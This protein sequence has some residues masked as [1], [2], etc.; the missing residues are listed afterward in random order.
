MMSN[1]KITLIEAGAKP[2][3]VEL[4]NPSFVKLKQLLCC[5]DV[6][7]IYLDGGTHVMVL[8][9]D[10]IPLKRKVNAWGTLLRDVNAPAYRSPIPVLGNVAIVSVKDLSDIPYE[11]SEEK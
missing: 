7:Y 6:E 5:R 11:L 1:L 4:E 8:D 9:E 2:V 10:G 3:E